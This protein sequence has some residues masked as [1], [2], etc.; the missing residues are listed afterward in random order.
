MVKSFRSL[1][2]ADEGRS[3]H[4]GPIETYYDPKNSVHPDAS[5]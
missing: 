3:L 4:V 1:V 5:Y 2:L